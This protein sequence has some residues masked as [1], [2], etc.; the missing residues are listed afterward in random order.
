M[1]VTFDPI[2]GYRHPDHIKIHQ[3]TVAAFD[4]CGSEQY[5]GQETDLAPYQPAKLYYHTFPREF[6]KILVVLDEIGGKRPRKFGKNKDIDLQSIAEVNYPVDAVVK[7]GE[8]A[9]LRDEASACHASQGGT[10][11]GG[12]ILGWIRQI[13]GSKDRYMRAFPEPKKVNRKNWTCSQVFR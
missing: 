10:K 4:L 7:F 5:S 3:A 6:V 13:F 1:V 2:G 12:G 11:N 8:V 9:G